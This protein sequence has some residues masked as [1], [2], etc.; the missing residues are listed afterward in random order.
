ME[1]NEIDAIKEQLRKEFRDTATE[2]FD[3][4]AKEQK[5]SSFDTTNH[6]HNGKDTKRIKQ[7]DIIPG[8]AAAGRITFETTGR[9][10]EIKLTFNPTQVL[11]NGV[12]SDGTDVAMISGCARLTPGG[13]YLQPLSPSSVRP[14]ETYPV[15]QNSTC[16]WGGTFASAPASEGHIARAQRSGTIYAS[17]TIPGGGFNENG[18]PLSSTDKPYKNGVLYLDFYCATNWFIIG[19]F[20]IS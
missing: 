13:Y 9:R 18:F 8:D 11:F 16:V 19:N 5:F 6:E 4:R 2:I 15:V 20:T 17:L 14:G 10:Y 12:A 1:Q 3:T 7:R